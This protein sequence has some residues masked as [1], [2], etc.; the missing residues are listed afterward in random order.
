[1]AHQFASNILTAAPIPSARPEPPSARSV[2]DPRGSTT[3]SP[4]SPVARM[5]TV[6]H[7]EC[8]GMTGGLMG[9]EV[10]DEEE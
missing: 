10:D 1:M 6:L 3:A 2:L 9:Q 7:P 4:P 8:T 5:E